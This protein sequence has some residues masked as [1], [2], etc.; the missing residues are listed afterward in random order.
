MGLTSDAKAILWVDLETTGSDETEDE[1]IEV[2]AI[3]TDFEYT[4]IS[5]FQTLRY[6]SDHAYKR[7]MA[8]DVVRQMHTDNGLLAKLEELKPALK[9][10]DIDGFTLAW[11]RENV[12]KGK[13]IL[14][15]SG[16]S[17]FDRKF[18]DAQMWRTAELLTYPML[19]V[20]V[21][22]RF[23]RYSGI[24]FQPDHV[25]EKEHRAFDDIYAHLNEARQIRNWIRRMNNDYFVV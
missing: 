11:V 18:I 21:I 14:A 3:L 2:G 9:S 6:P 8:N 12:P 23:F 5:N 13:V 25:P 4:I 1:I 16:V 19:D 24:E 22:R 17:H 15:G 20:G 7:L 10:N